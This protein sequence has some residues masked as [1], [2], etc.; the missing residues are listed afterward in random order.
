[1]TTYSRRQLIL[2]QHILSSGYFLLPQ[3]SIE[4]LGPTEPP[5]YLYALYTL[6]FYE[7][8]GGSLG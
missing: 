6:P 2:D 4:T 3:S 8:C 7:N 1:M 5:T